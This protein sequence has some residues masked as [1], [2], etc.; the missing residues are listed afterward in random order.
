MTLNGIEDLIESPF[1]PANYITEA[2][3]QTRGWFYSL[4]ALSTLIAGKPPTSVASCWA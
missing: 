2:V 4:L 1:F 3:D